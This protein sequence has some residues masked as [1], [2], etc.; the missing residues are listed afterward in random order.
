VG[1]SV[2]GSKIL[3]LGLAYKANV[4]DDRESPSYRLMEKLEEM[5]AKVDY[6]DPYI[7]VI[8][9]NKRIPTVRREKIGSCQ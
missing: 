9:K 3:I 5:G 1:K 8:K 2:K 7:P 4:D 6:N